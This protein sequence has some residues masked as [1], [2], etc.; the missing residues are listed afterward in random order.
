M[1]DGP[2]NGITL[3]SFWWAWRIN[4]A[5]GSAI[6]GQP[7]SESK[8]MSFPSKH[9]FNCFEVSIESFS[10]RTSKLLWINFF[11]GQILFKKLIDTFIFSTIK[12]SM[13]LTIFLFIS[14]KRLFSL[15]ELGIM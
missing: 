10:L 6:L 12:W 7:A 15:I 1:E 14:G 4:P 11:S 5:P 9:G 8:P 13:D 3:I 2:T